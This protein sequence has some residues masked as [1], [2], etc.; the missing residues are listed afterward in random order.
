MLWRSIG[1]LDMQL[2]A[3]TNTVTGC[4]KLVAVAVGS[5]QRALGISA[6]TP[7]VLAQENGLDYFENFGLGQ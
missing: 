7:T 3:S 5:N 6:V 4:F 2:E 1:W